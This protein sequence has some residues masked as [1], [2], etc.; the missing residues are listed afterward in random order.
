[1]VDRI[2]AAPLINTWMNSQRQFWDLW[3]DG[4]SPLIEIESK[5][6]HVKSNKEPEDSLRKFT[7]TI[8]DEQEK[9]L[10][11]CYES[12]SKAISQNES[13]KGDDVFKFWKKELKDIGEL[14]K[15]SFLELP[16]LFNL[17]TPK[18]V[19]ERM[20]EIASIMNKSVEIMERPVDRVISQQTPGSTKPVDM[21]LKKANAK[22][23]RQVSDKH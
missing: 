11:G 21:P 15:Q 1:M 10:I 13:K 23:K 4:L 18:K 6:L 17:N 7:K 16:L 8:L 20:E 14:E 2:E 22:Q 19:L 9:A 3:F 12:L 5:L